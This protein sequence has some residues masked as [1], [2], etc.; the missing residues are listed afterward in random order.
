MSNDTSV[1]SQ[2][3]KIDMTQL[4]LVKPA[5]CLLDE[6]RRQMPHK[7][8]IE[9]LGHYISEDDQRRLDVYGILKKYAEIDGVCLESNRA[10]D[11]QPPNDPQ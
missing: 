4:M 1:Q 5:Y 2:N 9:L 7:L 11:R 8:F 3:F 6:I 10:I